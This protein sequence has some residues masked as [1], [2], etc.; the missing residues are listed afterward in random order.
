[1]QK[2]K[3]WAGL[4]GSWEV[5]QVQSVEGV[6]WLGGRGKGGQGEDHEKDGGDER[7]EDRGDEKRDGEV[8]HRAE[9][10]GVVAVG[11][12]VAVVAVAS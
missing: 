1:M 11:G 9:R 2:R 6:P 4:E 12:G 10:F 8:L 5:L 7:D 3:G